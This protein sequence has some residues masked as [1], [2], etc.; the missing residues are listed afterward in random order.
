MIRG[1]EHFPYNDI[2][3]DVIYL[4]LCKAFGMVPHHILL[5]ILE[6]CGFEGWTV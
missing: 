3:L 5:S 6:K 1:L 2:Y 4:D